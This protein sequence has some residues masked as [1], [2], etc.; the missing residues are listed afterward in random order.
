MIAGPGEIL[1]KNH[2]VR[3]EAGELQVAASSDIERRFWND[4]AAAD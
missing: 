3:L 1:L 2:E 4:A